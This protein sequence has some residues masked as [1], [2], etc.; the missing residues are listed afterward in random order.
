MPGRSIPAVSTLFEIVTVVVA[1]RARTTTALQI[2]IEKQTG[3][4]DVS[5]GTLIA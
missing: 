2:K 5:P 4:H 1:E 3:K